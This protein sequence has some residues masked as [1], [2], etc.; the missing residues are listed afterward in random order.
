MSH[1][2][3]V[4]GKPPKPSTIFP[5]VIDR[6]ATAGVGTSVH[7]PHD[8]E[9]DRPLLTSAAV[10]V[11]RGLD[12]EALGLIE[13]LH[14]AGSV[15]VNPYPGVLRLADRVAMLR[16]LDGLPVPPTRI[17]ST[18]P[19]VAAAAGDRR[20]VVKS[21]GGP[22]RGASILVG[23]ADELRTD[24]GL[25]PPYLVQD[26]VVAGEVDHK[27]YV[28]GDQVRGLRKP[29]PLVAGHTTCGTAFTPD[30]A[31]ADLARQ[32]RA[33]MQLDLLG[34]DVLV[35]EDGPVIVDVNDFPGY[36]GVEGAPHLVAHHLQAR[37]REHA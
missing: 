5:E 11:H 2:A 13:E 6:L 33:R 8:D 10:V 34:V 26:Y 35:S 14:L 27:L 18:W 37:L 1:V 29:S 9:V 17:V 7:L 30:E 23:T 15:L 31:L 36:R 21:A 16:A 24:P 32:V 19:E 28:I 3:F 25:S 20:S 22:G 4:L 12:P